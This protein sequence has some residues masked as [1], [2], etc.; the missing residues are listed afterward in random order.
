[1]GLGWYL[2]SKAALNELKDVRHI[3]PGTWQGLGNPQLLESSNGSQMLATL[4][5]S[6]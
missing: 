4:D 1:M 5:E 6:E 3:M 2:S